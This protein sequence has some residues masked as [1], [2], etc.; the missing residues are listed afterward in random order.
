MNK[1]SGRTLC[2]GDIHG[3]LK[4]LQQV[5][6]RC[7]Y[8]P[9]LDRLIFLGDYFDGWSESKQLIDYLLELKFYNNNIIFIKGNHDQWMLEF[10]QQ[11]D[12]QA[13]SGWVNQG[14][15]ATLESYGAHIHI[16]GMQNYY[17]DVNIPTGHDQFLRDMVPYHIYD[18]NRG[19]VHAGYESLEGLGYEDVEATYYWDRDIAHLISYKSSSQMPKLLRPHKELFIGHTTTMMWDSVTPISR[20]GRYFNLDTGGGWGGKLTIMDVDTKEYWQSDYV[21]ELYPNEKGR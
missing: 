20:F 7:K 13:Y 12:K 19:F 10:I 18:N 6:K 2:V 1:K 17:V 3:G 21:K 9:K 11:G 14:G 8:D 16:T 15:R 5:L 4:S